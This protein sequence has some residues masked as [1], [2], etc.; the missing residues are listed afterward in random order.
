MKLR[1]EID[2]VF[3]HVRKAGEGGSSVRP[4]K[5]AFNGT[6]TSPAMTVQRDTRRVE[7]SRRKR[8]RL[9]L[10]TVDERMIQALV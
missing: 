4:V 2:G 5:R 10:I 7:V 9:Q 8:H 3:P 1:A 6:R